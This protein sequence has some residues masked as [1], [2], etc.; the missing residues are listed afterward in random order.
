MIFKK[1]LGPEVNSKPKILN[2]RKNTKTRN[3]TRAKLKNPKPDPS[4]VEVLQL[5]FLNG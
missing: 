5:V 2:P 3:P 1:K 4:L